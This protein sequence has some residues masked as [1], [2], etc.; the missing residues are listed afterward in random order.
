MEDLQKVL[1]VLWR[2]FQNV[3]KDTK[4]DLIRREKFQQVEGIFNIIKMCNL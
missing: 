3:L 2:T 4:E 1:K